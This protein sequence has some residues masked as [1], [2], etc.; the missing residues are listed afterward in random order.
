MNRSLIAV[1]FTLAACGGS[2][3]YKQ[4]VSELQTA[5]A[6]HQSESVTTPDCAL[7]HQRYDDAAR[8]LLQRMTM[9]SSGPM[10]SMCGSMR[11]ELDRHATAACTGDAATNQAEATHHCQLMQDWLARQ[12]R[13]NGSM[14]CAP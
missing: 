3:E 11:G 6:A 13:C 14:M 12:Q 8:P 5:V 10:R 4:S 2:V 9:M 1:T 7:E